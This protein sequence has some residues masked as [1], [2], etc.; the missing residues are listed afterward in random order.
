M[1]GEPLRGPSM[2][3]FSEGVVVKIFFFFFGG[4]GGKGRGWSYVLFRLG[5]ELCAISRG[6]P[7]PM[8]VTG[9][10]YILQ[11][12]ITVIIIIILLPDKFLQFDWLRAV[13]FP[14]NL[15]YLH[16]KITNLLWVVV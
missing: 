6:Y 10:N 9:Q 16:V 7:T 8:Y 13:V 2:I 15:K 1:S 4:G 14:L 5:M 12:I 3:F 11:V